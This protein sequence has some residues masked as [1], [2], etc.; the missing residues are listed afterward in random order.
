MSS[1]SGKR[2]RASTRR[3]L[4]VTVCSLL[5]FA[6]MVRVDG[7]EWH[8]FPDST[9][10][11]PFV[12][13]AVDSASDGDL[14]HLAAGIY[15]E[16]N[17]LVRQKSLT[18]YGDGPNTYAPSINFL[19][20]RSDAYGIVRDLSFDRQEDGAVGFQEM[21]SAL[22]ERCIISETEYGIDT[23]A[24]QDITNRECL[25]QNNHHPVD[26]AVSPS[27][28]A[29]SING[30]GLNER[31]LIESCTFIGNSSSN[32][33]PSSGAGAISIGASHTNSAEIARCLFVGNSC[34]TGGAIALSG[35]NSNIHHNLFVANDAQDAVI[36]EDYFAEGRVYGNVFA[37][38]GTSG[39]WS[40]TLGFQCECNLF[41]RN[42][43]P[44]PRQFIGRCDRFTGNAPDAILDPLFCGWRD[45]DYTVAEMS[46]ALL[47]NLPEEM[48]G[49]CDEGIDLGA[50]EVGCKIVPVIQTSWGAVKSRF[51]A[52]R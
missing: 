43:S 18:I 24:V 45:G 52:S 49:V 8:V 27:G 50:V 44:D 29:I 32:C 17:V 48:Q 25:F 51:G 34:V 46:P 33:A 19:G 47:P 1:T 31:Y 41:W 16:N 35:G 3:S 38:N 4:P 36:F 13:A 40:F 15:P 23:W 7:R 26:C 5:L 28:G 14:I 10:D 22:V 6:T 20:D 30:G 21:A 2:E 39:I 37:H 11:A 12:Q 42:D 9:G